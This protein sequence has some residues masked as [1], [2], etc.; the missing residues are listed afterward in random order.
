[1][2]AREFQVVKWRSLARR[3]PHGLAPRLRLRFAPNQI[4]L[5]F[6]LRAILSIALPLTI[7]R[8]AGWA[9]AGLYVALGALQITL[10]GSGGAYRDRVLGI[11]LLCLLLPEIY[12]LGTQ[13]GT[14]WWIAAPVMFLLAFAS[15]M[16][17]VFGAAGAPLGLLVGATYLVGTLSAT[18]A[19]AALLHTGLFL[20]GCLWTLALTLAAWWLRPYVALRRDVATAID[21]AATLLAALPERD[22]D[23]LTQEALEVRATIE[24]ARGAL[25]VTHDMSAATNDALAALY[26]LLHLP[27]RMATLALDLAQLRPRLAAEASAL[28]SFDAGCIA[29]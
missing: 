4:M 7:F 21:A 5:G 11:V 18:P 1:M 27:S 22:A 28:A 14:L 3:L 26:A 29:L 25:G 20:A 19:P 17:R 10:G 23:E 9:P 12:L 15:G 13:V 16:L 8:L 6:A 2:P 24:T